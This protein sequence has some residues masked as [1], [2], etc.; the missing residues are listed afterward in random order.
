VAKLI[1]ATEAVAVTAEGKPNVKVAQSNAAAAD[2]AAPDHLTRT[3]AALGTVGYMSPEQVRGERLDARTDLFSLGLVLYEMATGERAFSGQTEAVLHNQILNSV[4]APVHELNSTL[5]PNL[6]AVI[7]KA[8]EKDRELRYQSASEMRAGLQELKQDSQSVH[9]SA[10]ATAK[11]AAGSSFPRAVARSVKRHPVIYALIACT[12]AALV[13]LMMTGVIRDPFHPQPQE[14]HLAV[15]PFLNIGNDPTDKAFA[16]GI[17]ETLTSRLSQLERFQKSFWVVPAGDAR[18]MKSPEEAHRDLDVNLAVTGSV[19]HTQDGVQ[20]TTNLIDAANH[21]QLASRTLNVPSISLEDLQQQVWE[22]VA[23]MLDLQVP[24]EVKAELA[25]GGT[26]HPEAYRLYEQANGYYLRGNAAEVDH[27]IDLYN[28][29][30]A[31]DPN[32]AMAYAGLG[33]A[34]EWKYNVTRDP[35]WVAKAT[36][37]AGRAVELNDKLI[38]A[39]MSL[40]GIYYATGQRDKALAEYKR[41]LEQDPTVMEAEFREGMIYLSK[42][43][44]RAAEDIYKHAISRHPT[45]WEGYVILGSLYY[46]RGRFNEAVQQY[47]T[48]AQLA[49]DNPEAYFALGGAYLA[50]GRY[51]DAIEILQKGLAIKPTAGQWTNL[52][53]AYM[54][55]GKWEEAAD[56]MKR[57]TELSPHNDGMWRNL[58]D[59][60]DQIP[61]RL[62]DAR[63]AYQKALEVATE[64]LKANP[65]N[66]ELLGHIALYNAHLGHP[67]AAEDYIRRA[68]QIAPN[69]SNTLFNAALVYEL[70]GHRDLALKAVADAV[71][72]GYSVEEIDKEPELRALHGDPRYKVWL[73][74]NRSQHGSTNN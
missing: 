45:Y 59:A 3:G 57:A 43:Q 31:I 42:G 28:Q 40:A 47:Q 46:G 14:R 5:P 48:A 27:T 67:E 24:P 71:K 35:Q 8:L 25:A 6:E 63:Q 39:R 62:P 64:Q 17:S 9:S 51:H 2:D 22:A 70:T 33:Q 54:Y 16:E 1:T 53:A 13:V 18:T 15:L 11:Q 20:V 60:Y 30:L 55:L 12:L 34:Y 32:Y 10:A 41:V 74:Q 50:L 61:S 26:S 7:A 72:A 44:S 69:N 49:P 23:D 29:A 4:P 65:V 68:L 58:G 37:N 73:G 38:P 66:R 21:R 56:A 36:Q 52:G 19:E